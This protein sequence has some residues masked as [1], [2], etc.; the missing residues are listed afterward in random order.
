MATLGGRDSEPELREGPRHGL[1]SG[2]SV[3]SGPHSLAELPCSVKTPACNDLVF[4][5]MQHFNLGRD[6]CV[7]LACIGFPVNA[8]NALRGDASTASWGWRPPHPPAASARNRG[9]SRALGP[10]GAPRSRSPVQACR[11]D[12]SSAGRRRARH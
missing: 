12:R 7:G 8:P 1:D 11:D 2:T 6:Y 4:A 9:Q 5:A 3:F 10:L